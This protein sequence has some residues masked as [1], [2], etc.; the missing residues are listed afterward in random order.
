MYF[1]ERSIICSPRR[2]RSTSER[3]LPN[4]SLDSLVAAIYTG[5][6]GASYTEGLV[7]TFTVCVSQSMEVER[8]NEFLT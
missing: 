6:R 7:M 1:Q 4:A 3:L 5:I 8:L 2:G